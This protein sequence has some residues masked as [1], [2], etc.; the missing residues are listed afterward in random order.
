MLLVRLVL[1]QLPLM[2]AV[3]VLEVTEA[4]QPTTL[5]EEMVAVVAG[6]LQLDQELLAV[7]GDTLLVVAVEAVLEVL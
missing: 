6:V 3:L 7:M 5:L 2:V 4:M 1:L